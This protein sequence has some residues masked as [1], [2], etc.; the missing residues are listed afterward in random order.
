MPHVPPTVR[1]APE[2]AD[3]LASGVAVVALESTLLAHG[4]P[5]ERRRAT[6][7]EIEA[8]VRSGGAV[9]ATIAVLDGECVVGL[10]AVELDRLCAGPTVKLSRRDLGPAVA[11]RT[12]GATTVASTSAVAALAG[13]AVFATGGLGG[14]H[15]GARDSWDESG[16]LLVLARTPVLVVCSG[17]TS[18][19]DVEATLERL[20]SL[21]VTLLGYRSDRFPGFYLADSGFPV[22]WRVESPEEIADVVHARAELGLGA[23]VVANP[24]DDPLDA[25]LHERV[26]TGGLQAAARV[27]FVGGGSGANVAAW[28]ASLGTPVA[29]ACRV[30]NDERGRMAVDELLAAGVEVHAG[31]DRDHA[32]GTC[33]VLVD[34]EGERT[35]LPDPGA[36]D[37][38]ALVPDALLHA[39]GH[40]HVI[41]YALMRPG[42]RP[43][44]LAAIE[45]AHAAGMTVSVDPSSWALMRPGVFPDVDLLVPNEDEARVLG[46][47]DAPEVVTKLGA[48]GARWTDGRT[49]VEVPAEPVAAPAPAHA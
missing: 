31:R 1:I 41:G 26:L 25:E 42:A 48:R 8:A 16:D 46:P 6:A 9:P 10:T 38:P 2:V 23:I 43:G 28:A 36:N 29:L 35:M 17:V 47:L 22:P 5:P 27:S 18:I 14:V 44:A 19:L 20:E 7:D 49:T 33:V 11:A 15:R 4:L 21:N 12:L 37:M 39:G 45:R 30:G 32:T 13:I 3:A 24:L 34:S 40:L